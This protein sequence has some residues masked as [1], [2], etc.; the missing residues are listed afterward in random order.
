MIL[1]IFVPAKSSVEKPE[2][3][4]NEELAVF[5][6]SAFSQ[7]WNQSLTTARVDFLFLLDKATRW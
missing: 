6:F 5:A 7:S 1:I 4:L 2:S 3:E